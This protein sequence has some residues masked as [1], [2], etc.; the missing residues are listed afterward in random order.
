M[1][2]IVVCQFSVFH[3][4]FLSSSSHI[5]YLAVHFRLESAYRHI[6]RRIHAGLE[7]GTRRSAV[8]PAVYLRGVAVVAQAVRYA[9]RDHRAG[10]QGC[11]YLRTEA[12][13][14]LRPPFPSPLR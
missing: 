4:V 12:A 11:E 10:G 2:K 13:L 3:V 7:V 6:P 14:R 9:R 5:V 1:Q 8:V